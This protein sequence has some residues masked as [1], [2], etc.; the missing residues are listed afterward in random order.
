VATTNDEDERPVPPARSRSANQSSYFLSR[1][2]PKR[3]HRFAPPIGNRRSIASKLSRQN[4]QTRSD[5]RPCPC[6]ENLTARVAKHT[7]R[8]HC[9]PGNQAMSRRTHG[10]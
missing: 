5:R 6:A 4:L 9:L 10:R 7:I 8:N 3:G 2:K 1:S